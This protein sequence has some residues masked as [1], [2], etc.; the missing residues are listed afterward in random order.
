MSTTRRLLIT[1]GPTHEPID[2]VRYLGNRSSGKLGIALAEAGQAAGWEIRLL[3]GPTETEMAA[4][5]DVRRFVSTADL[6]GLLDE[7]LP[8]CDA[9]IMTAAVAD[10]RPKQ[11]SAVKLPRSAGLTLELEPTEDLVAAC[12]KRKRSDQIIIGFALEEPDQLED[13][14]RRKMRRKALDA[15]VANPLVTMGADT[16]DAQVLTP[17]EQHLR[18]GA[19]PK[20]QFAT[21]LVDWI[22]HHDFQSK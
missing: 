14:A 22:G 11:R 16:I 9:L 1:A 21:W 8:W 5:L 12:V 6:A 20:P 4:G 13:R 19:M 17:D 10:Y 2:P 3:M 15:I 7:H 18:P